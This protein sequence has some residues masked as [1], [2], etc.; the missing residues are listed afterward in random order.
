MSGIDCSASANYGVAIAE[1]IDAAGNDGRKLF[2]SMQ[3]STAPTD[4]RPYV[5]VTCN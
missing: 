3:S 4:L 2:Y 1:P 5:R